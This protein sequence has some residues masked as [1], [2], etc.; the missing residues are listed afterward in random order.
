MLY[1]HRTSCITCSKIRETREKEREKLLYRELK[2]RACSEICPEITLES[3]INLW[4]NCQSSFFI[5]F[6]IPFH[7]N[8]C[9][10][11]FIDQNCLLHF[12]SMV[13]K[14]SEERLKTYKREFIEREGGGSLGESTQISWECLFDYYI[15]NISIL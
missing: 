9:V 3:G 15:C 14:I 13:A 10:F 1:T 8:F 4:R 12:Y 11:G 7:R 2:E 6:H 5:F